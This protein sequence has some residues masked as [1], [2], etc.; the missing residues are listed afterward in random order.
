MVRRRVSQCTEFA[1]SDQRIFAL[2]MHLVSR[3]PLVG[4]GDEQFN[5]GKR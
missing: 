3:N 4:H 5:I 1:L 2:E